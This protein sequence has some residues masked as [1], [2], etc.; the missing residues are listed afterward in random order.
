MLYDLN[1]F[2]FNIEAL[3]SDECRQGSFGIETAECGHMQA[4]SCILDWGVWDSLAGWPVSLELT[5]SGNIFSSENEADHPLFE[6]LFGDEWEL[7]LMEFNEN[8]YSYLEANHPVE[9]G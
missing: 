8:A 9:I 6:R 7:W 1:D 5:L 2:G 3:T 4:I